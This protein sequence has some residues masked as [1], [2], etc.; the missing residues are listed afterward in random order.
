VYDTGRWQGEELAQE[1]FAIASRDYEVDSCV[2][3]LVLAAA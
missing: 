2:L 1:T 3:N